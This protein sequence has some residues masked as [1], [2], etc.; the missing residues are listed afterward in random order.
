WY[1]DAWAIYEERG[2]NRLGP[3]ASAG[4]RRS[5][6]DAQ[7]LAEHIGSA[8]LI[9]VPCFLVS[10]RQPVDFYAGASIY[11][12]VQ[13]LLLAATA[14]GLGATL[15][16]MQALSGLDATGCSVQGELLDDLRVLL[17]IPAD[18]VPAAVI[19]I[20][21]PLERHAPGWRRPVDDIVYFDEWGRRGDADGT[22][23]RRT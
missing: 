22:G 11:P 10:S 18:V 14:V 20:G 12:A 21:W 9:V 19:P 6:G 1:L 5:V 17:Q 8:P 15:T 4:Q 7:H 3:H 16:T 2:L 23:G 13:N